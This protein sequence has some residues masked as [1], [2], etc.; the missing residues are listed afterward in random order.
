M[1]AKSCTLSYHLEMVCKPLFWISYDIC[2]MPRLINGLIITNYNHGESIY[3][4]NY[5]LHQNRMYIIKSLPFGV[6]HWFLNNK[7]NSYN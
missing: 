3:K 2:E 7:K 1:F 4:K 6:K 5:V